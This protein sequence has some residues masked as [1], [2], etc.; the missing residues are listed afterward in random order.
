MNYSVRN[1]IIGYI[2]VIAGVLLILYITFNTLRS[3][4]NTQVAISKAREVLQTLGPALNNMQ[5]LEASRNDYLRSPDQQNIDN[6]ENALN[7]TRQ[8]L[9]KVKGLQAKVPADAKSFTFLSGLMTSMIDSSALV[10]TEMRA[11]SKLRSG[12]NTIAF[13][14]PFRQTA[15]ILEQQNRDLLNK[16]YRNSIELTRRT[17]SYIL[18]LAGLLIVL[19]I[20][21]Y[22]LITRNLRNLKAGEEQ[23]KKFNEKLE[24]QVT[25]KTQEIMKKEA[26]YRSVIEQASDSIMVTD[27]KGNFIEVNSFLCKQFGY[28][29]E[30]LMTM[31]ISSLIDPDQLKNDPIR[32]DLMAKG[33]PIF[34]ERRM[35]HRDGRIIE[36]EANVKMLPDGRIMAIARDVTDRKRAEDLILREKELSDSIIN[37][38][39]GVFYV[40]STNG[41]YLRWN[42]EFELISGYSKEEIAEISPLDFFE[43]DDKKKIRDANN[44]VFK[45]GS[46]QVEAVAHTKHGRKI[47]Y[48]FTGQLIQYEGRPCLI[49]TGIDIT[50][51]KELEEAIR[52]QQVQGQKMI[53]R[54]VLLAE[55]KERNLIGQELHDNVNQILASAKLYLT[56]AE[57]DENARKILIRNC[58][59]YIEDAIQEI[60]SLSKSQVTPL[61]IINLE[62]LIDGLL[63]DLDKKTGMKISFLYNVSNTLTVEDDLKLNIYRVIQEQIN[64]I[65]KHAEAEK[66]SVSVE[67]DNGCI[68]VRI[69]DNGKGFSPESK[70]TGIG[71]SNMTNR[72]ESYNGEIKIDSSPGN[73]CVVDVKIPV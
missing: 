60:R 63:D 41:K 42:K 50:A 47:P 24:L 8:D 30:E 23:L 46:T 20:M 1:I 64:N 71:L 36:V 58:A 45:E 2:A 28:S 62:D 11:R 48:F 13:I 40:Q 34:R 57:T 3:Q 18:I 16:S 43:G 44:Q 26:I 5:L 51:R 27:E 19:L 53:T 61:K 49:G 21:T 37:S 70:R 14:Q 67:G 29:R 59:D 69:A 6:Y 54:A 33:I 22:I 66:V 7:R 68:H 32:F 72:V 39:P 31:N 35:M 17:F 73:G 4:E 56:M 65:L 9:T 15:A 12:N 10:F 55:E 52:N 38:L 25:E